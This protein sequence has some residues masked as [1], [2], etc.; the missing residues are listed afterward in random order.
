MQLQHSDQIRNKNIIKI[1]IYSGN[2]V[3]AVDYFIG[4]IFDNYHLC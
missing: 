2:L 3:V 4:R 1:R